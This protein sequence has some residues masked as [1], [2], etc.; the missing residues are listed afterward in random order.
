MEAPV[1]VYP[2]MVS[3]NASA[4]WGM[5]PEKKK[6]RQLK[7]VAPTQLSTTS[8]KPPRVVMVGF[9]FF[10]VRMRTEE[11]IIRMRTMGMRKLIMI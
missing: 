4:R 6:G 2:D 9:T 11:P 7:K 3:K 10:L 8:R 5:E 1:V